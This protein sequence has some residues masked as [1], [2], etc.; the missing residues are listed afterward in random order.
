MDAQPP[1]A[2][3]ANPTASP[4]ISPGDRSAQASGFWRGDDHGPDPDHAV[5]EIR[6]SAS[7]YAAHQRSA[8][9]FAG[10]A[11]ALLAVGALVWL[12]SR[13]MLSVLVVM[14]I[15]A[16]LLV[17]A[18]RPPRTVDYKI[19]N[20]G[21]QIGGRFYRFDDY[22]SFSV[23]QE[24]VVP[25]LFLLPLKRFAPPLSAFCDPAQAPAIIE[26]I[27]QYLPH[28]DRQPDMIDRLTARLRL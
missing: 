14:S 28:E 19:S 27:S 6:W 23:L 3:R 4:E 12:V 15:A 21:L 26:A 13:E 5:A 20:R 11:A 24:G 7:E 18:V 22:R 2:P 17:L 16:G 9:W 25:S 1:P 10:A 8:A